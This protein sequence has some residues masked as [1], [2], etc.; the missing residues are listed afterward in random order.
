MLYATEEDLISRFSATEVSVLATMADVSVALQDASEEADTYVGVRF[1]LPL[2]SVPSP[3]KRA[4]C[5]IARY[6]LYKDRPTEQVAKRYDQ[7]IDWLKRLS[8]GKVVL[9]FGPAMSD[10]DKAA[11]ET[12]VKPAGGTYTGSV[13]SDAKLGTMPTVERGFW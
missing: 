5:D 9:D 7:A 12:P 2:P 1:T 4:V 13:F 6:R 3:L 8:E 10:E 11:I